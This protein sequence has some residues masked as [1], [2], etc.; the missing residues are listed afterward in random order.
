MNGLNSL[1]CSPVSEDC[2]YALQ[3]AVKYFEKKYDNAVY[4]VIFLD[5]LTEVEGNFSLKFRVS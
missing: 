3:K 5:F 1:L 2:S 4:K